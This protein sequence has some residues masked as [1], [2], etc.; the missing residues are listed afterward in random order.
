MDT[1]FASPKVTVLMPVYNGEKYLREAI[2]SILG[3]T[4]ADF[5]FL[6]INDGSTDGSLE[7]LRPYSDPRVRVVGN[8]KNLGL[9]AT[10]NRGLALAKGEYVARM[11]CD[12]ISLPKRLEKQIAFMDAHPEIG[13]CGTW[14][15]TFGNTNDITIR[16]PTDPDKIRCVT[17]FNSCVSH[18]SIVMRS[19]ALKMHGIS[20]D[21]AYCHAED[22]ALWV[23]ALQHFDL[24][25]I[26]EV[27]HL[28]RQHPDQVTVRHLAAQTET[29]HGIR[30]NLLAD[31]GV[32]ASDDEFTLH[33]W[34]AAPTL[35]GA[36]TMGLNVCRGLTEIS[37][38]WFAKLRDA[39]EKKCIFPEPTFSRMLFGQWFIICAQLLVAKGIGMIKEFRL[40]AHLDLLGL[41]RRFFLKHVVDILVTRVVSIKYRLSR[42]DSKPRL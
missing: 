24:A 19:A 14:V 8:E 34:L 7:V 42:L 10:L 1:L 41:K 25:N 6:I 4:F 38:V 36:R 16:F 3:Q 2:D 20:Y 17:F 37:E 33:S 11:D 35:H 32:E 22:Y 31:L 40:F 18:P 21:P 12:D 5:E 27:L 9:V 23:E 28:Y 13:I 39:N 26:G 29:I 30:R 15:K